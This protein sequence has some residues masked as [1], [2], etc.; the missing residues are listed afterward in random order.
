MAEVDVDAE[1]PQTLR[2]LLGYFQPY[3]AHLAL[4]LVLIALHSAI[5][6]ALV[7]L[8]KGLLDEVLI[9]HNAW[10]LRLLPAALVGIYLLNGALGFS[11]GMLT[12][13]VAW[14]V[15]TTL[16]QELFDAILRQDVAW[17]QQQPTGAL[18][19]RLS[20]DVSNVQYG[21]SGIVT[22]VQKPLTLAGL[23]GSAFYMNPRLTAI[24]VLLLPL[25]I[26][27]IDRFG[28]MLRARSRGALDNMARLKASSV[29]TLSG[30]RVVQAFLAEDLR[31]N[32]FAEENEQQRRLKMATVRAQLLPSPIVELFAAVGA[33]IALWVGGQQVFAGQL[34]PGEL[35]AFLFAL[36]FLHGPLKGLTLIQSL[37]QRALAG[38]SAIF[39]ILD[40]PT[41]VPDD[42]S[43]RIRSRALHLRFEDVSFDYGEGPVLHNLNLD[44]P[45]GKMIAL[46]GA[47]GAGKSTAANLIPRFYDPTNGRLTIN[48]LDLRDIALSQ[49]RQRVAMVSQEGFL[50]ND[51]VRDNIALGLDVR[52]EDIEAAARAANA[53]DFIQA[54]P[55]GYQTRIDELGMRLS[56]GQRQ[57][58]AIARAI[59][60]DAPLLVLDEA[61][62]ALD[63][64]SERMVQQALERL[65]V[66]RTVLAIAHRLSTIRAA[67]EIV[68]LD[69]GRVVERG[70][71]ATLMKKRGAYAHLIARQQI[72]PSAADIAES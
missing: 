48:G 5:P 25:V 65:M 50:F 60:R 53:H 4:A 43:R 31:S 10:G 46:V 20:S 11:R 35:V 66:D 8:I 44:L 26:F 37:T 29:E 67:D 24:A 58:I 56:G 33:G 70:D 32:V 54:L 64:E 71:H 42:G 68:V 52:D 15:V 9:E 34:E 38:A 45:P 6:G 55:R 69:A 62:S 7:F 16:R 13:Y 14:K 41:A 28:K 19:S 39:E 22:A 12:R 40:R 61:T 21:V 3:R 27:P 59:L 36:G 49:L 47:S 23:V 51:T 63:A 17:H 1:S 57:R 18:L 2:R 72:D 30:I